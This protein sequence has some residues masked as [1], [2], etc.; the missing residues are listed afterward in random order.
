[1]QN[2]LYRKQTGKE[3]EEVVQQLYESHWYRC[4][5][6]NFTIRGGEID[7]VM[8]N[9]V[10]LIFVEVKVVNYIDNLHDYVTPRKLATLRHTIEIY[11]HQSP[12]SKTVRVDVV[13]VK[14]RQVVQ[15]YKNIE[16]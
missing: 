2:T 11:L 8:E 7:L 15:M 12:T 16:L 5:D 6:K 14:N 1:M 13:F 10:N 9:D 4:R 3:G